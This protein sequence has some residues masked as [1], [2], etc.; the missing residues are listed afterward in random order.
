MLKIFLS[1]LFIGIY[2]YVFCEQE[3]VTDKII[4]KLKRKTSFSN[5]SKKIKTLSLQNVTKL[6]VD[7]QKDDDVFI[8]QLDNFKN[9][10]ELN[11]IIE[12]LSKEI[13]FDYIEPLKVAR[14]A[15]VPN[16]PFYSNQWH[17]GSSSQYPS[18]INLGLAWDITK[19]SSSSIVA[20]LDTG[21][22]NHSDLSS[23]KFLAGYDMISFSSI[24]NDGDGRDNNPQ[25]PGDWCSVSERNNNSPNNLCYDPNCAPNCNSQI[26]S[27]WHGLFVTGIIFEDTNNSNMGAGIN[28]YGKVLPV[29]VLGKG[30]G[31]VS[32]I[33]DGVKWACGGSVD[34]IPNNQNSAKI[35]NMSLGGVGSCPTYL[36]EAID[37]C[38]NQGAV[39]VVAAGNRGEDV[40]NFF[41]ANCSNVI[42]V[43]A[44]DKN[45]N[46][47]SYSNYGSLVFISAPGGSYWEPIYSISNGGYTSPGNDIFTGMLGTSMAAPNVSG[48][49][50]LMLSFKP[51]LTRQQ[52]LYN[53]RKTARQF[54]MYSNCNT[55]ICGVGIIDAYAALD[56]LVISISS[57]TPSSGENSGNLPLVLWGKGFLNDAIV[58]LKRQGYSDILCNNVNVVNLNQINCTLPLSG[59]TTGQWS[60]EVINVD[61]SSSILSN[62]FT[63]TGFTVSSINPVSA[64]NSNSSVNMTIS[65]TGFISPMIVRLKKTGYSEILCSNVVVLNP[66]TATCNLNVLGAFSGLRDV[67]IINGDGKA[68]NLLNAFMINNATPSVYLISPDYS[69]NDLVV[70]ISIKGSG[71]YPHSTAKLSKPGF[72]DINCS[73]S[74]YS[75]TYAICRADLLGSFSGVRDFVMHISTTNFMLV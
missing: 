64:F 17:F 55:S 23:S 36:Q 27:S 51:S 43:S 75:S 6:S 5:F 59:A 67:E 21:I 41:P 1:L 24:A 72:K 8:I 74:V 34:G 61:G 33:A 47:A 46:R 20:I 11:Y 69:F 19:G 48:I 38:V 25:D 42:A 50:S 63:I 26:N 32:D 52:I 70:D 56:N 9:I 35:I 73:M 4:V 13:E 65:G 45:G 2:S 66:N 57:T 39:V 15:F 53:L 58:K 29:R 18:A 37:F 22:L 31:Y 30:G 44:L 49:I 16:D 54:S 68:Q 7:L 71:F 14:P 28:W 12:R 40:S 62:Y 10:N 60:V 3:I